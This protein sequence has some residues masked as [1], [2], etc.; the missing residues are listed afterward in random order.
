MKVR[1]KPKKMSQEEQAL[2]V[3][4]IH[5]ITHRMEVKADKVGYDIDADWHWI[6]GH[7]IL[8]T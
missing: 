2:I 6:V 3:A 5:K 7:D 4:I 1:H 8:T